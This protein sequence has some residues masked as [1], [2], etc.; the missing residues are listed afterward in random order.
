MSKI[1]NQ[2]EVSGNYILPDNTIVS[3]SVKSNEASTENM[4]T[5]FIKLRSADKSFC[6]V[7]EELIETITLRNDSEYT[8]ENVRIK[9]T[10]S[11]GL[12]FKTGTCFVNSV[13]KPDFDPVVGFSLENDIEPNDLIT[14]SYTATVLDSLDLNLEAKTEVV[15]SVNEVSDLTEEI[16]ATITPLVNNKVEM[17]LSCDKDVAI[18][19]DK[20]IYTTSIR[21]TGNYPNSDIVFKNELPEGVSFVIG[22]VTINNIS[23]SSCD[24]NKGIKLSDLLAGDE[25]TIC[26]E[27]TVD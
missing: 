27:A 10:L 5:S 7:G 14:I 19:G 22:S 15:Y 11:S 17:A 21:N 18:K 8:I 2:S 25:I 1:I 12:I 16:E 6:Y 3:M 23:N 20:L 4:T 24:P 13:S 9:D 26:F